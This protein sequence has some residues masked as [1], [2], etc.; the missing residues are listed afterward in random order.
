MGLSH[1]DLNQLH[2]STDN[3]QD[4]SCDTDWR[5]SPSYLLSQQSQEPEGF[6]SADDPNIQPAQSL[7]S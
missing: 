1:A 4:V 2:W 5:E 7:C 3:T 6:I